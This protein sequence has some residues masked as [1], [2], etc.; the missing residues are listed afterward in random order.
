[1]MTANIIKEAERVGRRVVF[2]QISLIERIFLTTLSFRYR[3][4]GER[5]GFEYV[6]NTRGE[7]DITPFDINFLSLC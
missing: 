3:L 7:K 4:H 2:E 1:M 6:F 5:I